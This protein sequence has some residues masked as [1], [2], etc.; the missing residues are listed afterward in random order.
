MDAR[1]PSCVPLDVSARGR[2][3][4]RLVRYEASHRPS[5]EQNCTRDAEAL[6]GEPERVC[7][8]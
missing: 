7:F 5:R 1:Y 2:G 3:T 4:V 8:T 6:F